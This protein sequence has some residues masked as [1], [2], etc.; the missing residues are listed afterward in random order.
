MSATSPLLLPA[1][2]K[3]YDTLSKNWSEM[4]VQEC[5]ECTIAEPSVFPDMS[6]IKASVRMRLD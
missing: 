4:T 2:R 5:R 1:A 3:Y 6:S